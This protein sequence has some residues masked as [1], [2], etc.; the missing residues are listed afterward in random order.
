MFLRLVLLFTLVPMIELYFLIKIGGVIGAFSTIL[1][2]VVTGILGASLA[3]SQG[4][5]AIQKIQSAMAQNQMPANEILHGVL[6]LA[7]GITLLTP[8]FITDFIGFSMMVPSIREWVIRYLK[9][10]FMTQIKNNQ[11]TIDV[12]HDVHYD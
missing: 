9:K 7:G 4:I 1:V 3:R 2:I 11:V 12:H 10:Y 6:I 8:G 5:Q